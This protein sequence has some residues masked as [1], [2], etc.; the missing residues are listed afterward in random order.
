MMYEPIRRFANMHLCRVALLCAVLFCLPACA[1]MFD[2]GP[3]MKQILLSV[4]VPPAARPL[5]PLPL[6]LLV[7]SPI[8]SAG[9]GT[10][11]IVALMNGYEIKSLDSA[12]WLEPVP[13]MFQRLLIETLD[14]SGRF[15]SVSQEE[16]SQDSRVR[17]VSEISHFYLRYAESGE[18]PVVE[19]GCTF[20][21][22][23][24]ESGAIL[25]R[26]HVLKTSPCTENREGAIVAAFGE[27]MKDV[28]VTVRDWAVATLK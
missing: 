3:P 12:K 14:G 5:R 25:G 21:L 27:A 26:T 19:I 23:N 18:P 9:T 10:D 16:S 28:L 17:L 6:Q 1:A 24:M 2:P 7:M 20:T 13:K 8:P 4:E 11:R 15:V 22:A